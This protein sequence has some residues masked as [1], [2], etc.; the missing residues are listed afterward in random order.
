MIPRAVPWT[1]RPERW[2]Q[3]QELKKPPWAQRADRATENDSLAPRPKGISPASFWIF[4]RSTLCN[5]MECSM[6]DFP[7]LHYLLEFAQTHVHCISDDI[8][9][10]HPLLSPSPLVFN[11][12]QHLG[13]FQWVGSSH[14]VAKVLELQLQHQSFQWIFMTDFLYDGLIGSPCCPRDSQESSPTPQF[15]SINSLVLSLLY[16]P[17]LTYKHDY[18]KNHSFD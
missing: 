5:T 10:S 3:R 6:P 17:S 15:K 7:V 9:P 14:Q 12:S 4:L 2:A 13:L 18:W 16:G 1:Q 11:P 8:Q